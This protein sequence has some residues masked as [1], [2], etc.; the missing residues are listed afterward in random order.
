MNAVTDVLGDMFAGSSTVLVVVLLLV[1]GVAVVGGLWYYFLIYRRQFDIIVEIISKRA[2][3]ARVIFDKAAILYDKKTKTK[4]LRL[5]NARRDLE[6]PPFNIFENTNWGDY[7]RLYRTSE[8]NFRFLAKPKIDREYLIKKDGKV[9]PF[10][11]TKSKQIENDIYWILDRKE[12]TDKMID[13]QG[14]LMKLLAYTPQIFSGILMLM[15]L[16]VLMQKLPEVL[17]QLTNL[18]RQIAESNED[19]LIEGFALLPLALLGGKWKKKIS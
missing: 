19:T 4:Y 14:I 16:Y 3:D 6:V 8:D 7:V 5:L 11:E 13:P 18:A 15:I 2:T 12:K 1:L 9:Y 10:S 17:S